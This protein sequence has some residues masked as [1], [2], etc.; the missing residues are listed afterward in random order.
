[1]QL[2]DAEPQPVAVLFLEHF[3]ERWGR[4]SD[5]SRRVSE[6]G[7]WFLLG[8]LFK[9]TIA[10]ATPKNVSPVAELK[11]FNPKIE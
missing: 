4:G 10:I 9:A 2:P 3:K 8:L 5:P 11:P 6:F 1:V 7:V